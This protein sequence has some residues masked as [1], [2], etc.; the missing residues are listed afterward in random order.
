MS[1]EYLPHSLDCVLWR[2]YRIGADG[3]RELF[4]YVVRSTSGK[5]VSVAAVKVEGG[6]R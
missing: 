4:A 3:Q 5:L 6:E 2:A 1:G